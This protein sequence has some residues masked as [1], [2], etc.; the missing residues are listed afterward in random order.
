MTW[1]VV[2]ALA[3]NLNPFGPRVSFYSITSA[4]SRHPAH[5]RED[6]ALLYQRLAAGALRV[7]ID[8]RIGF[9]EVARAHEDLERGGVAGKIVLLP[10]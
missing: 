9:A 10:D 8:R 6:L 7:R 5:F 1:S 4:R 2:S 3:R